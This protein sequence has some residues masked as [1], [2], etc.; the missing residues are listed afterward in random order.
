MNETRRAV[1]RAI[2][3]TVVPAIERDEDPQGFWS[4]PGS[5]VGAHEAVAEAIAQMPDPQ[6]EGLGQLLDGLVRMGFL[7]ASQRSRE[8]LLRN[9]AALGPEA[10]AGGQ[11]LIGLS[12][13]F[14]YSLPDE[15][16]GANPFWAQFGYPGPGA[17]P[18]ALPKVVAALVPEG[19][20]ATYEAD[21]VVVGS[22]AGG[23][24]IAAALA[25][26]GQRV[27]VLEAGGAFEEADFNG[28]ELWAYQNLYWRGGPNPTADM[29]V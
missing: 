2:A 23:G 21:A 13:F 4:R 8:Q 15:Q 5:D 24:V 17:P 16:T 22:G 10:A 6:R 3:D 20:E 11:A 28:Y 12:L 1:L 18:E 25:E 19:D 14:A 26:A 29:N 9:L 7:S 27:I